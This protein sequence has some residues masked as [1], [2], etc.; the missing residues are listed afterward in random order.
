MDARELVA[1]LPSGKSRAC[2]KAGTAVGRKSGDI[3][4]IWWFS[5]PV[6]EAYPDWP[7]MEL[8]E[9]AKAA[10]QSNSGAEPEEHYSAQIYRLSTS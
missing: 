1:N 7:Q 3:I 6:E 2:R 4:R 8:E 5:S 9:S 10:I